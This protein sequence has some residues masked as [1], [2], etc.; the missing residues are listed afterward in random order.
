MTRGT[1]VGV[2]LGVTAAA[3]TAAYVVPP[4]PQDPAYHRFADT[5]P[6]GGAANGWAVFSNL[7]F[8]LVGLWGLRQVL[9]APAGASAPFVESRERWP[10]VLFFAGVALTGVGSA[11]Y[12]WAP[13]NARLVWDRLPLTI[14]FIALLAPILAERVSVTAGIVLLPALLVAGAGRGAG[15]VA[16][17][18]PGP[19]GLPAYVLVQIP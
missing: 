8:V 12:H 6:L 1:R 5:R 16:G 14:G 15:R 19:G 10:Y 13:D 7:P 2:L 17:G 3:V 11:Y 18:A 9:M 4:I